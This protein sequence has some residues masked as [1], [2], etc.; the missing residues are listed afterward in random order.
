MSFRVIKGGAMK[1]FAT[2]ASVQIEVGDVLY[3]DRSNK[4]VKP[5]TS[6]TW[7]TSDIATQRA[8]APDIIGIAAGSRLASDPAG[9]IDVYCD[10][11]I[12]E[13]DNL[14]SATWYAGKTLFA[15]DGDGSSELYDQK[16]EA[17]TDPRAAC[18]I[19][20]N[21]G[22]SATSGLICKFFRPTIKQY[23]FTAAVLGSAGDLVTDMDIEE[24]ITVF[25]FRAITRVAVTTNDWVLNLEKNSTNISGNLTIATSG[26][27]IGKEAA[28]TLTATEFDPGDTLS[29]EQGGTAPGAGE[30]D[31]IVE[32]WV[33]PNLVDYI[34]L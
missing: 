28:A 25:G 7:A 17:V 16:L 5:V 8:I 3:Y 27:A 22:S 15:P 29:I 14:A 4:V 10:N 34:D 11:P 24:P 18:F 26:S 30:A 33:R 32:Y 21:Y 1:R 6:Y 31:L 12:V 13:V 20:L 23:M 9:Y 2:A 19:A